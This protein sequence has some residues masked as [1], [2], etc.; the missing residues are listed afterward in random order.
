MKS[1]ADTTA[2]W[3]L[4]R[5]RLVDYERENG[6]NLLDEMFKDL[7]KKQC[8]EFAVSGK[9][10]RMDSKLLGSNIAWISRYGIVHETLQLFYRT[11]EE[12]IIEKLKPAELEAIQN[13]NKDRCAAV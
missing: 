1:R 12:A 8:L 2:T 13:I 9:R 3:Y 7:T 11:N 5:E 6:I 4:F 10:V